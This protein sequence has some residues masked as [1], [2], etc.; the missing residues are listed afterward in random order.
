MSDY[1]DLGTHSRP[2]TTSSPQAQRWFDRGLNWI[3]GFNHEEAIRCFERALEHDPGCAMAWWGIAYAYGPH[4]NKEWRFY[5]QDEL[6]ETLPTV[7]QALAEAARYA[8]QG[9]PVER[10]LIKAQA[11]RFQS[12]SPRAAE[13]MDRWNHDYAQAMREVYIAFPEDRDVIA[14]F[15]EALMMRTPWKLWDIHSGDPMPGAA[16]V[17]LVELLERGMALTRERTLAPHP[18]II[19]MY[20]HTMEMSPAPEKAL[21]PADRLRGLMPDCGHLQHMPSHIDVLCGHYQAAVNASE[22]AIAADNKY[23]AQIGPFDYYTAACCHDHH[24]MMYAAMFLGQLAPALRSAVAIT[25]LVSEQVL[26]QALPSLQITLEAYYSM[27]A[28]VWIRFGKWD[29]ILA[30]PPPSD[31][32]LYPV[33]QAMHHYSR[34]LALANLGRFAEAQTEQGRFEQQVTSIPAER[35]LFNNTSHT[36][37]AVARE[38]LAGE[39]AYHQGQHET[40]FG[41]LRLA[42]ELDDNLHY[43]EPWAWMHPPRHALGALLLA[44]GH[45]GEAEAVYRADL[46]F[47]VNLSRACQHPDNV[48]SLHGLHEC[49]SRLGKASEATLIHQRLTL[50]LARTDVEIHASCAC[51]TVSADDKGSACH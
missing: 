8:A 11:V 35:H 2:V 47:D 6:L 29:D 43:T 30:E 50:A 1:Y 34:G 33:T 18:G 21:A 38:M 44:Q 41:H 25:E 46:G 37:L 4:I 28:H 26:R 3:Y 5:S 17:E 36:V 23:L 31:P 22:R 51:R 42:V 20:I 39:L 7:A 32:A 48:W 10:A 45:L 13:V 14:L 16:T 9:P 24:L 12:S 15:G 27:K 19:H 40:A 49:L